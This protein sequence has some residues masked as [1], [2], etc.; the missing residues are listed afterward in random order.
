MSVCWRL[1]S[2]AAIVAPRSKNGWKRLWERRLEMLAAEPEV[3]RLLFVEA[4]AAGA[5]I[6]LRYHEWLGRYGTLL[7]SAVPE[8]GPGSG[9]AVEIDQVI[10]GGIASRVAS[11]V[12]QGQAAQL[13]ILTPHFVDYVLAFYGS[14]PA[15][16]AGRRRSPARAGCTGRARRRAP[17]ASRRLRPSRRE[18]PANSLIPSNTTCVS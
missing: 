17:Q 15:R 1:S 4:P 6:A 11:E 8:A 10:V 16:S 12:L 7:R 13:R 2:A 18:V 9:L 3:A 5:E 14:R